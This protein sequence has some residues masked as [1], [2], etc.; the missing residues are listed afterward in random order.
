LRLR[1]EMNIKNGE[2]LSDWEEGI[3]INKE[4]G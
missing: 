2:I 1:D 3:K 4:K